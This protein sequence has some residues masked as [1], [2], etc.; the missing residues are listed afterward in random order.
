MHKA[1]SG[2]LGS[3]L[4]VRNSLLGHLV[5]N[6]FWA[7]TFTLPTEVSWPVDRTNHKNHVTSLAHV[8]GQSESKV[9]V[10]YI[11]TRACMYVH[12]RHLHMFVG[13]SHG[14]N[15]GRQRVRALE[16][17]RSV[18]AM[19]MTLLSRLTFQLTSELQIDPSG[20]ARV[21]NYKENKPVLSWLKGKIHCER[22][23]INV[24]P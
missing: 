15:P 21:T 8:K 6:H 19:T 18:L 1:N 17:T 13:Q 9:Q 11:S 7:N 16:S 23:M 12:A 24:T 3:N 4:F 10:G 22:W 14:K 2:K 20:Y 5:K